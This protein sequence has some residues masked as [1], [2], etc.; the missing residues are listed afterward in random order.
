MGLV[1]PKLHEQSED[2]NNNRAKPERDFLQMFND[3]YQEAGTKKYPL[4]TDNLIQNLEYYPMTP[5]LAFENESGGFQEITWSEFFHR[6]NIFLC[7][8]LQLK[9]ELIHLH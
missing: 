2:I 5:A 1:S 3:Y 6:C 9:R 4:L 7:Q 8:T